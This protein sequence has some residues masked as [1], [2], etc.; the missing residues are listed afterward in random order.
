MSFSRITI[1]LAVGSALFLG[2]TA[3]RVQALPVSVGEGVIVPGESEPFG[4]TARP[5]LEVA[6][7]FD[8]GSGMAGTLT[9]KFWLNDST[10]PWYVG[11][12]D[13][14]GYTFTYALTSDSASNVSMTRLVLN[15]FEGY[16]TDVSYRT[17]ARA[18]NILPSLASRSLDE[19]AFSFLPSTIDPSFS[20]TVN[21]G[22]ATSFLV[23][24]TNATSA[25]RN[26]ASVEE[27]HI[28]LLLTVPLD[29]A[30]EGHEHEGGDTGHHPIT[31]S[32]V[33]LSGSVPLDTDLANDVRFLDSVGYGSSSIGVA[34]WGPTPGGPVAV[35]EPGSF[36]LAAIG[37][38]GLLS[39]GYCR[40]QGR[41]AT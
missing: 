26:T 18:G 24:Q 4:G 40:R 36:C 14:N 20:G 1:A 19:V 30:L 39:F 15:S 37:L 10:S 32:F 3:S 11:M 12:G 27:R 23:V 29:P 33:T 28:E 6:I 38:I 17:P 35:P 21:P 5:P 34:S 31:P 16:E 2:V 41:V 8:D 25:S 7:P 22:T 9:S 13:A